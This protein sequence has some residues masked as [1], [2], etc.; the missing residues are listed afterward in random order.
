MIGSILLAEVPVDPTAPD[1]RETI[2]R[3]L[4]EP[5]YQAAQPTLLDI[6]GQAISDWLGSLVV[7]GGSAV[8]DWVPLVVTILVAVGILIALLVWGVPRFN[9]RSTAAG[10]LFGDDERRSADEIRK[11]AAAAAARG[12]H[13]AAVIDAFRALARGL[14]ER[15]I[16]AVVPGTTAHDF[17]RQGAA[18]FPDVAGQFATSADGFD[19]VRYAGAAGTPELYRM[20]TE[21]DGTVRGR[22]AVLSEL[23]GGA[24]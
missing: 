5:E 8:V 15:T 7:P 20:I 21:L 10:G 4:S 11:D 17:A 3:E 23:T 9:R 1:A 2:L 18:A 24:P 16:V 14:Q 19:A 6:V 12:D 22:P 13:T